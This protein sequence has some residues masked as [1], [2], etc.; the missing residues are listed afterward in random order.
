M[1]L[2][3]LLGETGIRDF[4]GQSPD[5]EILEQTVTSFTAYIA[6]EARRNPAM[7]LSL[8]VKL[9][10]LMSRSAIIWSSIEIDHAGN[11]LRALAPLYQSAVV[12]AFYQDRRSESL[13]LCQWLHPRDR[14]Y[15]G[16]KPLWRI[17][18]CK[19]SR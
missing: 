17:S 10:S 2:D 9:L 7:D 14:S 19:S 5:K 6:E 16:W 15:P 4:I 12:P 8:L 11:A 1:L 13:L 18:F 3:Q